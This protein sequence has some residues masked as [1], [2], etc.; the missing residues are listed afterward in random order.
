M[1]AI[2]GSAGK[3]NVPNAVPDSKGL[4]R[5]EED[6]TLDS[7]AGSSVNHGA[8]YTPEWSLEESEGSKKG[9]VYVAAGGQ[10]MPNE[11]QRRGRL[12][13]ESGLVGI[14]CLQESS[15]VKKP[16]LAVAD[17]GDQGN[18]VIFSPAGSMTVSFKDPTVQKIVHLMSTIK[19]SIKVHRVKFTYKIPAWIVPEERAVVSRPSQ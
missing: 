10:R 1:P 2:L 7:G 11:G 9:L 4:R 17:V 15:I 5:L 8:K 6:I 19:N 3:I 14:A 16:L 13:F 12:M 18:M